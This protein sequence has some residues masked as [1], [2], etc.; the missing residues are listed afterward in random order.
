MKPSNLDQPAGR[1]FHLPDGAPVAVRPIRPQDVGLLAAHLRQLTPESRRNRFLG[2]LNELAPR[3]LER[4]ADMD[5]VG[6]LALLA[7]AGTARDGVIIG[8]AIGVMAPGSTRG[9]IALS[10][11]DAW[12]RRGLG[13][14]LA[15]LVECRMR[16][17]GARYLFG[18]VLRTNTA[19]KSLA[20]KA[21]FAIVSPFTDARLVEIVKDLA[22]TPASV[23]CGERLRLMA[24]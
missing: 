14:L 20:R 18:D 4:I 7:F 10:V 16:T 11:A 15:Q 2:A 13:M 5:R 19:M 1:I 17:A 8:E 3:E 12:Q 21:G 6:A 9:E 24:A 22:A 23:L